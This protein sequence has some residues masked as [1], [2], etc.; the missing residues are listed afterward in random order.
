[1]RERLL[2]I[3]GVSGATAA[4]PLPLDG[5]LTNGRW[6]TET[7]ASDPSQFRQANFHG[8]LPGYFETLHTRLVAGRFFTE[9]DNHI[10][11]TTDL[12]RQI[13]VDENLAALAFRGEPAVGQRLLLRIT[14]PAAE[15]YEV[16]GVVG[17]QRHSSLAAAGPEAIFVPNGH[18]GHGFAGR[19]AV[20]T[21]GDP[22]QIVAAVRAA[23]AQ[24]DPRAPL[25]EIQPM[26]AFVDKAMAPIRFTT[27]LIGI[28]AAVA[29]V[30][31]AVGL[32]GVLSTIV[33]Q[34]TAEIGMRMVFGAPRS[35]ILNLIVGEGLKLSAA[36]IVIG[37][38]GAFATT[39]VMASMLVGIAPTDPLTF[40]A[41]V[42]LFGI[43]AV[44][45]S[46]LPARRASRLDPMAA[47]R[48][49]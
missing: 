12:P 5:T 26:T 48:E 10:D 43:I 35:S 13:I 42:A 44:T 20:R 32:S 37:L 19:W 3:P 7:A 9:A 40:A 27:T 6:G 33:R 39:R 38:A 14:T 46:W 4:T 30:L 34:R 2:A 28:F 15:W 47:I 24:V 18:F 17:H 1:V 29:L 49:E 11:Q 45:A 41:I 31:A 21:N 36:G 22:N 8:V 25:A 16:I 23:V